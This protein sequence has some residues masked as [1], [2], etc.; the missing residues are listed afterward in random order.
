M[1]SRLEKRCLIASAVAHTG[2]ALLVFLAPAF[3]NPDSRLADS[4]LPLEMIPGELIDAALAP[5]F[6]PAAEAS[7]AN[8]A[9]PA[10]PPP[11]E[12]KPDRTPRPDPEPEPE[13]EPKPAPR[14]PQR[15]VEFDLP[16]AREPGFTLPSARLDEKK[17]P[18]DDEPKPRERESV[19]LDLSKV[20]SLKPPTAPN[21]D[22]DR[23][24]PTP[25]EPSGPTA[26]ELARQR[27]QALARSFAGASGRIAGAVSQGA[28]QV[29]IGPAGGGGGGGG[30][31]GPGGGSAYA[32]HVRNAFNNAWIPP[33]NLKDDF[34]T[35]DVEVVIR[36]DGRVTHARIVKKSGVAS[37]DRSV[38]ETLDRVRE[39]VPF[40]AEATDSQRTYTIEFN[41]RSKRTF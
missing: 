32:W 5:G 8:M 39:I 11:P 15:E 3:R 36:K 22:R 26:E 28:V 18:K 23:R 12:P 9:Q 27:R 37:L 30:G 21:K 33:Q 14:T 1:K 10:T 41:L 19:K 6:I 24:K 29:Q 17:K 16:K 35:A 4:G 20:K 13:R 40:E 31:T 38:Q 25:A 7:T 2:L 34:A